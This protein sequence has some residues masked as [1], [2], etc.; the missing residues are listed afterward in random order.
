MRKLT[1]FSRML[2]FNDL[3]DSLYPVWMGGS[4]RYRTIEGVRRDPGM[5]I[6]EKAKENCF[7]RKSYSAPRLHRLTTTEI[8]ILLEAQIAH[9][10]QAAQE[11]LDFLSSAREK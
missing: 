2:I 9:G 1:G 8:R 5:Y 6:V 3:Q 7:R 4:V 10:D 11:L